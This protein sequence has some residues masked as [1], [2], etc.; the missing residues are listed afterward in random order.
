VSSFY[1]AGAVLVNRMAGR[2]VVP[3]GK[4]LWRPAG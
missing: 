4:A 3:V 1:G 2:T